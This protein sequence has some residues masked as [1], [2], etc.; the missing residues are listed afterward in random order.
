MEINRPDVFDYSTQIRET[1]CIYRANTAFETSSCNSLST[2]HALSK[3]EKKNDATKDTTTLSVSRRLS[4]LVYLS[5][6]AG[7]A[8]E[9]KR[10]GFLFRESNSYLVLSR[11]FVSRRASN[12]VGKGPTL[13]EISSLDEKTR[14]VRA[15]WTTK[16]NVH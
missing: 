13:R 15:R 16:N 3:P 6:D 12:F 9:R 8:G 10:Y 5:G 2:T 7:T 1:I 4:P 14:R 11:A